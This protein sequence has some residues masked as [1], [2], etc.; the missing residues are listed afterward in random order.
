MSFSLRTGMLVLDKFSLALGSSS[1]YLEASFFSVFRAL[2][3]NFPILGDTMKFL[4]TMVGTHLGF[5][6]SFGTI[7][8]QF[9]YV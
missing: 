8:G 9:C 6:E 1:K 7:Q 2:Y 3:L 5:V 4:G